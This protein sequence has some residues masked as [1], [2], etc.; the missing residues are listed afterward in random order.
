MTITFPRILTIAGSDPSGGAGIEADLKT[1]TA[2]GGYGMTAITAITAQN[3]TGVYG[4]HPVPP[5]FAVQQI[6]LIAEDIGIDV[7]KSGMLFDAEMIEAVANTLSPLLTSP[8]KWVEGQEIPSPVHGG[9]LGWG[10][11]Y[12]LDPVMVSTSGSALLKPDAIDALKT[13]LFPLAMLITPNIP[14]AE[15]LCGFKINSKEDMGH[16][17]SAIFE[18]SC[19]RMTASGITRP[20]DKHGVTK[21]AILIK[22]GHLPGAEV[23]DLLWHDGAATWFSS[24]KITSRNTHGTGCTLASAIATGIGHGYSLEE[25]VANAR[26]YVAEAIRTAPGFGQGKGPLNHLIPP[27]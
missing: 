24:P 27:Q 25:A 14:E 3:T 19:R 12:V 5:A 23:H 20:R 2:F 11:P 13:R 9:G 21:P 4:M 8:H 22:G 26:H 18:L 17:A 15:L 1:I 7:I 16:A 6:K 10:L